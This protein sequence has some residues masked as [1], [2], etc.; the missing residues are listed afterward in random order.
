MPRI[1]CAI[2]LMALISGHFQSKFAFWVIWG[3]LRLLGGLRDGTSI[4]INNIKVNP[5]VRY[6]GPGEG[7]KRVK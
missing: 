1:G 5:L 2:V 4:N 3:F 6:G 7:V